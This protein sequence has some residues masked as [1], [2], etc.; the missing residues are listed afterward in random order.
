MQWPPV[1]FAEH[2]WAPRPEGLTTT[3]RRARRATPSSY[4]AA[5]VPAI[6]RA[7]LEVGGDLAADL[8]D[9][10][11]TLTSFDLGGS[12][13]VAPFASILLRS[14]SAASSHIE[15]LTSSARALAEAAIGVGGRSN[16]VTILANVRTMQAAM[17]LAGDLDLDSILQMH[18]AL[19]DGY[20][21]ARPG[22]LRVEQVWIGGAGLHPGDAEFVPPVAADVPALMG[23]LVA[24][25][26]RDDIPPLALA[27]LAHAQFETIHPFADGNGRT[28]RAL[29]HAS[30]LATGVMHRVT[31]PI[32]AGLLVAKGRYFAALTDYRAGDAEP[33]LRCVADA[34]RAGVLVGERL[35]TGLTAI[36]SGWQDRVVARAD[37]VVWRI[38]DLL[39]RQ[40]VITAGLVMTD[41]EV[42]APTAQAA[43]S[44]LVEAEVLVES[45]G[46]QR[47]RVYRAP[48]VLHALDGYAETLGRRET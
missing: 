3:S 19:M 25:L 18:R 43:L 29:L 21:P 39:M 20:A 42:S 46:W 17:A 6:G 41:L 11:R 8:D 12:G 16:A 33:I 45:T 48:E 30:L 34:A 40:P 9:A 13:E 32:S 27:T 23:D 14:E 2:P 7:M 44:R 38:A 5:V 28:G 37:S 35:V 31:V 1:A 24:F 26:A 4:R 47:N 15:N 36:R 22:R 10:T